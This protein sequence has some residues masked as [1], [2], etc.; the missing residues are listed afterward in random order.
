MLVFW[1]PSETFLNDYS[2]SENVT[3]ACCK[4]LPNKS[5]KIVNYILKHPPYSPDFTPPNLNYKF[6]RKE[7]EEK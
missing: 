4:D 6:G 1:D 2:K 3:V 7:V 5:N